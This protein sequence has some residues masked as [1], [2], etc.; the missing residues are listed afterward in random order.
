VQKYSLHK[1]KFMILS[2]GW[3]NFEDFPP[4]SYIAGAIRSLNMAEIT[5]EKQALDAV[6]KDGRALKDVPAALKTAELCLLAI[7]QNWRAPDYVPEERWDSAEFC[8]AAVEK[9]GEALEYVPE[10]HQT[11][12]LCRAAVQ[13]NGWALEYVPENL[14]TPELCL[15]AVRQQGAMLMHVPEALQGKV[16]KA[17]GIK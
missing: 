4:F 1:K 13:Q 10:K 2:S 14:K 3:V 17:A 9:N 15:E 11:A 6:I 16:K 5:T 7:Q 8:R 12:E